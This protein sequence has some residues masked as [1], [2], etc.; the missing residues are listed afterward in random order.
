MARKLVASP[1]AVE[2]LFEKLQTRASQDPTWYRLVTASEH[3]RARYDQVR[4]ADA[5]GFYHGLLT[6]YAVAVKA[7]QGKVTVARR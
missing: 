1:D 7:L 3:A 2:A 4:T 5:K 6:G